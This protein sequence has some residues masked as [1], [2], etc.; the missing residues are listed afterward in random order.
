MN[1][2]ELL[3]NARF[4]GTQKAI[5]HEKLIQNNLSPKAFF[6]QYD[7]TRGSYEIK[8]T[9]GVYLP[10][11]NRLNATPGIGQKADGFRISHNGSEITFPLPKSRNIRKEED[12]SYNRPMPFIFSPSGSALREDPFSYDFPPTPKRVSSSEG[13][14]RIAWSNLTNFVRLSKG[15]PSPQRPLELAFDFTSKSGV[16]NSA[17]GI[18][19]GFLP[20][21]FSGTGFTFTLSD[22]RVRVDSNGNRLPNPEWSIRLNNIVYEKETSFSTGSSVLAEKNQNLRR[23]LNYEGNRVMIKYDGES[24]LTRHND[25]EISAN[26]VVNSNDPFNFF[27]LF[28][29]RPFFDTSNIEKKDLYRFFSN[30]EQSISRISFGQ[31]SAIRPD[32]EWRENPIN[33]TYG[34]AR[35]RGSF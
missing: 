20:N 25:G 19:V 21:N 12:I 16:D 3:V 23:P 14:S 15:A 9:Q 17:H 27:S 34:R 1:T 2:T 18:L 4:R 32:G 10:K 28:I 7:K 30:S 13:V 26:F 8:T 22:Q 6:G 29:G 24:I 31:F 11:Q 5:N 35:E 33:F